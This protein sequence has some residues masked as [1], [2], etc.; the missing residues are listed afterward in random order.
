MP[1]Y[2]LDFSVEKFIG[3]SP[4]LILWDKEITYTIPLL[5]L[6]DWKNPWYVELS[7]NNFAE[8]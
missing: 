2:Y 1:I 7:I 4:M 5:C 8:H 3:Y 6:T